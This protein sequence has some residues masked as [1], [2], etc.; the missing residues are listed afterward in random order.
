MN[1]NQLRLE[2]FETVLYDANLNPLGIPDSVRRAIMDNIDSVGVYPMGYYENLKKA[3]AEYA[4]CSEEHIVLRSSASELIRL[5]LGMRKPKK[6]VVPVPSCPEYERALASIGVKPTLFKLAEK[7]DFR[8]DVDA[9]IAKLSDNMDAVLIDNPS[10]P[11]SQILSRDEIRRLAE[12]CRDHNI[13]LIID[14]MYIEFTDE[15]SEATAVPLVPEFDNLAV[16]RSVSKFFSVPGLRLAYGIVS[17]E[18]ALGRI[19]KTAANY[20]ISSITAAAC[21]SMLKDTS[22]IERSTSQVHTERSLIYSAMAPCKTVR[23]FKPHANFM[24]VKLLKE[25]VT[26]QV[27]ADALI[28]KGM[29][30]RNCSDFM[31]LSNKYIRFCFMNPRQNDLLVNTLLE[32]V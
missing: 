3:I 8:L 11:A 26:A 15:F 9:L 17:N 13:F 32:I 1:N 25:E 22:Y 21:C 28:V 18:D 29:H 20:N 7:N 27:L 31:L 23:L 24:L 14:E 16:M 5:F 2:Q 4:R 6:V 10:N 30:I 12:A 19:T